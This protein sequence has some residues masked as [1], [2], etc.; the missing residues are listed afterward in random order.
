VL[1][2]RQLNLANRSS[3]NG[4]LGSFVSLSPNDRPLFPGDYMAFTVNAEILKR[5]YTV[6]KPMQVIQL[7]SMPSFPDDKGWAVVLNQQGKIVDELAYTERWHFAL[8]NNAEGVALERID[9]ERPTNQPD[10]WT[11]AA[12]SANF[13]TPT[14]QNSQFRTAGQPKG[15]ITINPKVFS[16]DNDGF[17]D[18]TLIEFRFPEPGFVANITV[19]DAA[20]RPVRILQRNVTCAATGSFRWDGLN[21][22]QQKVPVGTYIVFTEIFNL[23]GQKQSFKNTTV[24]AKKF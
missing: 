11:S 2:L 18:F 9:F 19:M 24:V 10:N 1:N 14:A 20:G 22:K 7:P 12:G 15:E 23:Q 4:Q 16:P 17:D 3:S 13:G 8:L 21:D 6:L 5:S